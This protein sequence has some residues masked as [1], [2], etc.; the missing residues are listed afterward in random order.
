MRLDRREMA[1]DT[2]SALLEWELTL[3]LGRRPYER[4]EGGSNHRNGSCPRRFTM[5]G[6]GEVEI[7]VPRERQG[8][9]KTAVSPKGRQYEEALAQDLSMLFL[10]GL[11]SRS[12]AMLSRRLVGRKLSHTEIS[13][14]NKGLHDAVEKWRTRDLSQEHIQ[15]LFIQPKQQAKDFRPHPRGQNLCQNSHIVRLYH[16]IAWFYHT[17]LIRSAAP[18]VPCAI[19][20]QADL[21]EEVEEPVPKAQPYDNGHLESFHG[22]LREELLDA[23]LFHTS[24]EAQSKVENWLGWYNGERPHQSLGY[25]TPQECWQAIP[26]EAPDIYGPPPP[27]GRLAERSHDRVNPTLS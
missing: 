14:A 12:L 20:T 21:E 11:S 1:G 26:P 18:D 5:K 22:S 10:A 15:F 16:T 25:A 27:P 13:N 19:I 6:I 8:T 17:F 9:F 4:R 23:E 24:R 7:K 2:L 3:H